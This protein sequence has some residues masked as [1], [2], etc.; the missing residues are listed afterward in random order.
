ML[1]LRDP[2][3]LDTG[4]SDLPVLLGVARPYALFILSRLLSYV[5]IG[6]GD[7]ICIAR[8]DSGFRNRGRS[9]RG[10]YRVSTPAEA[11]LPVTEPFS[12]GMADMKL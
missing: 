11:G 4:V 8:T 12:D 2:E 1:P 5:D 7:D 3:C 6:R 10:V 9:F